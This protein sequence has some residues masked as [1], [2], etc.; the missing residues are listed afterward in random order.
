M[1]RETIEIIKSDLSG[2]QIPEGKVVTMELAFSD[3]RRN[4]I[5]LD[6]SEEEAQPFISKGT[7]I[8]R[9]GRRPGTRNKPKEG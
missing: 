1:A 7:E 3:G 9:R 2:D 8:K 4:K 5:R 6:L